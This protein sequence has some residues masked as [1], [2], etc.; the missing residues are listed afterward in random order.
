MKTRTTTILLNRESRAPRNPSPLSWFGW[1]TDW[2][3][4]LIAKFEEA[5]Q[6]SV[7]E[8]EPADEEEEEVGASTEKSSCKRKSPKRVRPESTNGTRQSLR[9]VKQELP[10]LKLAK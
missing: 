3:A 6:H 10:K 8:M 7:R 5:S 2:S 9:K 4:D 1:A